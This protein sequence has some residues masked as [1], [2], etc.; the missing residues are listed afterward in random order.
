MACVVMRQAYSRV[1][2]IGQHHPVTVTRL[3]VRGTVE[4]KILELQVCIRAF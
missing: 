3:I 1:H 2:R 4:E